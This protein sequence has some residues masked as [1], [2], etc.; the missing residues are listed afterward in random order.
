VGLETVNHLADD[1]SLF[2][3]ETRREDL[4]HLVRQ[5]PKAG[6]QPSLS[7]E[8][9]NNPYDGKI[10]RFTIIPEF[11]VDDYPN[12]VGSNRNPSGHC[13]IS[14][15]LCFFRVSAY[16]RASREHVTALSRPIRL[17]NDAFRKGQYISLPARLP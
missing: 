7:N 15:P 9:W 5:C 3:D 10:L 14:T 13:L 4:R 1:G 16:H 8:I 6:G 11:N 12:D 2:G 17:K